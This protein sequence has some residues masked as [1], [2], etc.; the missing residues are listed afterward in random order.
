MHGVL[1]LDQVLSE[2]TQ[3]GRGKLAVDSADPCLK[4]DEWIKLAFSNPLP[5]L[6]DKEAKREATEGAT[7]LLAGE[8]AV[9]FRL[10][11]PSGHRRVGGRWFSNR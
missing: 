5:S 9:P 10:R 2:E 7:R 1:K 3:I 6:Q 4:I 11:W 8:A